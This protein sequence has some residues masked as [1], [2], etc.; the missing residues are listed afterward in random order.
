ML[1]YALYNSQILPTA[2]YNPIYATQERYGGTT[3]Q[4][5]QSQSGTLNIY[6]HL[7]K[8]ASS[9]NPRTY[10]IEPWFNTFKA[11]LWKDSSTGAP[12]T[13]GGAWTN[14]SP[15]VSMA[16]RLGAM[17]TTAVTG[18]PWTRACRVAVWRPRWCC[19][20]WPTCCWPAGSERPGSRR[21]L[22][23]HARWFLRWRDPW[24]PWERHQQRGLLEPECPS[25]WLSVRL[26]ASTPQSLST[27]SASAFTPHPLWERCL[28][29]LLAPKG[30]RRFYGRDLIAQPARASSQ[31]QHSSQWPVAGSQPWLAC[32]RSQPGVAA[33]HYV[34]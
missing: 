12:C 32:R 10:I 2:P 20:R 14:G 29:W 7:H 33:R 13:K 9:T 28:V 16:P 17:E 6:M 8:T 25:I 4:T 26:K 21:M 34:V 3:S 18:A 5:S 24:K 11:C 23:F 30:S 15:V 27:Q 22:W 19:R 1:S 31:P